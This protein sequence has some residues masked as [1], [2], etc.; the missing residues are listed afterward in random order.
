[1]SKTNCIGVCAGTP[2]AFGVGG[3]IVRKH[4]SGL[5]GTPRGGWAQ[6]SR[7]MQFLHRVWDFPIPYMLCQ[8]L[9]NIYSMLPHLLSRLYQPR[10]DNPAGQD[11]NK[12]YI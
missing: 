5:F 12:L 4:N 9:I 11:H 1:M 6:S 7:A 2:F 8:V 10:N 3:P